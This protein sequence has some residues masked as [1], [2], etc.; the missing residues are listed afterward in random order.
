[1]MDIFLQ[2]SYTYGS[3]RIRRPPVQHSDMG[4]TWYFLIDGQQTGPVSSNDLRNLAGQKRLLPSHFVRRNLEDKW[5]PASHVWGLFAASSNELP[6]DGQRWVVRIADR[7]YGP[8]NDSQLRKYSREGLLLPQHEIRIHGLNDWFK[9]SQIRGLFPARLR[10]MRKHLQRRII[11]VFRR[12]GF[13]ARLVV[14]SCV[15]RNRLLV[16]RS[17]APLVGSLLPSQIL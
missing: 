3:C 16:T 5:S 6:T 4:Q 1:M 14:K 15:A 2:Q 8:Y 13:A 10:L 7:E 11:S 12:F 17:P 9:A